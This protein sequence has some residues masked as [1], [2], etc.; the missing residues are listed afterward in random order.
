MGSGLGARDLPFVIVEV[1]GVCGGGGGGGIGCAVR[2][3]VAWRM[4]VGG[5]VCLGWV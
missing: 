3:L 4:R 1:V 2:V 5:T